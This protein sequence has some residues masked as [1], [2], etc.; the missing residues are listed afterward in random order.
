MTTRLLLVRHAESHAN[1]AR[2]VGANEVCTG[3][4]D[5]GREQAAL[6]AERFATT[7][8][9]PD[10]AYASTVRRA[11]ETCA[12]LT[13]RLG[14]AD[15]VVERDLRELDPGAAEGMTA[16]EYEAVYGPALDWLEEQADRPL[17]P[18][19][20][21]WR[22]LVERAGRMVRGLLAAHPGET[23]VALS[24]GGFIAAAV[25][26][27]LGVDL[28]AGAAIITLAHTSITEL[29]DNDGTLHLLRVGDVG[30][31]ATPDGGLRSSTSPTAEAT[32]R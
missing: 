10:V 29:H 13:E 31:L 6:L 8:P 25:Q 14:I 19:G 12:V 27:V 21:T 32:P 22:A 11:R 1:V 17:A 7:G 16:A 26:A 9:V 18:G 20:E 5:V 2:L 15:A 30:H 23:T 4:T 3:L 24:H 28:A